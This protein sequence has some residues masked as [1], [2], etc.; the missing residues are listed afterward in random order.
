MPVVFKFEH[1][2]KIKGDRFSAIFAKG[3]MPLA[4]ERNYSLDNLLK[5]P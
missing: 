2:E 5:K 4:S 1:L 3:H